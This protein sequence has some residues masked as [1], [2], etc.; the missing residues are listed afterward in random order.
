VKLHTYFR[1]SAAYRVRI[2]LNLKG[3]AYEPVFVHLIKNGGQHRQ[4]AYVSLNPQGLVPALEHDGHVITQSIAILEYLDETYP[5]VPL[6]PRTPAA[7]AQVRAFALA[8]ACDIH[9]LTNLRTLNYLKGP[10]GHDQAT[11][12]AWVRHWMQAGLA[13]MERLLPTPRS[14]PFCF[15]DTPTMADVCLVPLLFSARR[16]KTDL[17]PVPDLVA[18]DAHCRALEAFASAS[19]ER[20]PDSE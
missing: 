18:I 3:I 10:L 12:D 7:R 1:S 6:L 16:F 20:Q 4:P 15:G 17:G 19:P 5:A 2:A 14:G 11:A 13:P 8:A 9:P